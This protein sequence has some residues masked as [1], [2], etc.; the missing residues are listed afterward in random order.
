MLE[1][2]AQSSILLYLSPCL[3]GQLELPS[4]L[5]WWLCM[6]QPHILHRGFFLADIASAHRS[7]LR[8]LKTEAVAWHEDNGSLGTGGMAL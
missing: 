3:E 4:A 6:Q 1:N 7:K 8:P 2:V 5:C